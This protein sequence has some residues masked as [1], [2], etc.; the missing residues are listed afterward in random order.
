MPLSLAGLMLDRVEVSEAAVAKVPGEN[1]R[2]SRAEFG[3]VWAL[4]QCLG[5][6]P[7]PDNPYLI[8][9]L[10]TCRWLG[11]Q[12]AF[13]RA[14]GRWE[15]PAAPLTRR[16]HSAMPETIEAEYMAAAR[17]TEFERDFARG[18]IATLE[19]CWYVSGRPPLD[20][21]APAVG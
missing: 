21:S 7:G 15:M 5:S 9:V 11:R 6:E 17:A 1:L 18:V 2:V 19:W 13:S 16:R 14:I 4:A 20:V 12:P 10:W 8:G 3:A